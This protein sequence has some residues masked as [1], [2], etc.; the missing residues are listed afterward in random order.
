MK[1]FLLFVCLVPVWAIPAFDQED[2]PGGL[3]AGMTVTTD[4]SIQLQDM[5]D[6]LK[7]LKETLAKAT[8]SLT[9]EQEK[10]LQPVIE[11]TI[12]AMQ[13]LTAGAGAGASR[14]QGFGRGAGQ[15]DGARANRGGGLGAAF[16]PRMR[17]LNDQF[18][19]KMKA[20]LKPDQAAVWEAYKNDQIKRSGGIEALKVMLADASAAL[21]P[22]QEQQIAPLYIELNRARTQLMREGQGRPD[23]V[24]VKELE[25]NNAVQVAKFLNPAQKKALLDSLRAQPQ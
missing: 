23:P 14:G 19:A 11:E 17:E 22:E 5:A 15:G 25:A 2:G 8:I 1:R 4:Q 13:E 9:K 16:N 18:E 20:I 3:G 10:A 12:R 21:S 24:K 6:P 7:Q